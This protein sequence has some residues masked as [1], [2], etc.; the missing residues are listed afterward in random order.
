MV[1]IKRFV[2]EVRETSRIVERYEV[3]Q[4]SGERVILIGFN[5]GHYGV[6]EMWTIAGRGGQYC[7]AE[8]AL[9]VLEAD[10]A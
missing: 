8:E 5:V 9:A 4:S 6:H 2:G 3:E 7:S 10:A 1:L